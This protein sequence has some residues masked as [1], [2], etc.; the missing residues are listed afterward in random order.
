M[1]MV[2]SLSDMPCPDAED[3]APL[4]EQPQEGVFM[5]GIV[6][7]VTYANPETGFAV[8]KITPDA[9]LELEQGVPGSLLTVVGVFAFQPTPGMHVTA[10]GEWQKH[11]RFGRQFRARSLIESAPTS[12]AAM[13]AY[14]SSG[15]L[16]GLGPVLAERVVARFGEDTLRVLDQSPELLREVPGI[17]AKKWQDIT[18]CWAEK[19]NLREVLLFFQTYGVPLSLAQRI[20]RA[21]GE[22]AIETVKENPYI[23][24]AE[25]WGIGFLTADQIACA[26]GI[27]KRSPHRLAAG[28]SHVLSRAADDGHCYLPVE[29]LLRRTA[30]LLS[31]DDEE[32]LRSSLS[33]A[34]LRADLIRETDNAYLPSLLKNETELAQSLASHVAPADGP[35]QRVPE[36]L[37]QRALTS[38]IAVL[39]DTA[40]NSQPRVIH[41]SDEQQRAISLA[42]AKTLTVI[43]GGPGCGKTTVVRSISQLFRQAGL[44]VK[45]AAPTGRAAQRLSEVCGM[46][47]STIHRLLK[48]DPLNRRFIHDRNTPLVLD[49]LIVD[50]SSMIDITLADSLF[51]A[52]PSRARIVIV[53]DADQLPSVGPGLFLADLLAIE[54]IPRVRLTRLFRRADESAITHI[55]HQ[56]NSAIVPDIP[57]PDGAVKSDAY[58]LSAPDLEEAAALIERLVVDQLPRKFGLHRSDIMVL[59]P[60]NKGPLGVVSLNQRLQKN[61]V[62]QRPGL[63]CLKTGE[64]EFRLG[65]RICQRV[66]NYSLHPNGVFNGDRGEII[67]VDREEGSLYVRFWDG[68]EIVYDAQSLP[69]LDLAYALTIHRSQGSEVAAVVLVVHESHNI[70][71]ERQLVYTAVTRAKR[72]LVVVGT[73]KALVI[74]TR[75]NR[76]RRRYTALADKVERLMR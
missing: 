9:G 28:F 22:R 12:K 61:L 72:L 11:A 23:L 6:A 41:L 44:E 29:E 56:I 42:A 52:I 30:V 33:L 47:A 4:A 53:G 5:R 34:E 32:L 10:R 69:E 64:L 13:L 73:R 21:Y 27:D 68:R 51:A 19:R 62:P 38:S 70:L 36:Q 24:S 39:N 46:P 74:A 58:F 54:N 31:I 17:G 43:T 3:R 40:R 2:D 7:R 45:L 25:V 50:E 18:R 20:Y 66:N 49:A 75:R 26:L 37:L 60:M 57:E 67:G 63:P 8:L 59:T 65:D 35:G 16:R 55:A 14:L 1:I 71:L 48:Y 15:A 76:S